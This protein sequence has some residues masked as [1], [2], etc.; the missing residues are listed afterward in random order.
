MYVTFEF[1]LNY[2]LTSR[3]FSRIYFQTS[4]SFREALYINQLFLLQV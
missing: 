2:L 4:T 1:L 3:R